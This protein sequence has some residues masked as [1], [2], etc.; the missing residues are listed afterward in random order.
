ME[1]SSLV[2]GKGTKSSRLEIS[3]MYG[4]QCTAN[5]IPKAVWKD[6][7]QA[8]LM[9]ILQGCILVSADTR[10]NHV[11]SITNESQSVNYL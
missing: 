9:R 10:I 1:Y 11:W 7:Q 8:Y 5:G 4:A 3:P 2:V 6:G